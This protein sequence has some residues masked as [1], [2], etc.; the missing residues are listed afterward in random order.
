MIAWGLKL[1]HDSHDAGGR[2]AGIV[3]SWMSFRDR[4]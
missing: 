3:L 1:P 2:S 4:A